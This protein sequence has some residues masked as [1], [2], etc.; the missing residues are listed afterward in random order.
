[1]P[2]GGLGIRLGDTFLGMEARLHD[3]KRDAMLAFIRANKLNRIITSGG[4]NAEDRRHHH[5]QGL[6]R[7][8]P[9]A[10]RARHRRG[11]LQRPG[12][13]HLQGRLPVA[14][15][16]AGPRRVRQ[17]PRSHHRGRGEALADR[18]PGARG[19]L[20]HREP[21]GRRRQEGRA[22]QLAVPG[23]GRARSE[24]RR[25]LYRRAAAQGRAERADRRPRCAPEGSAARA[26]G[27]AGRGGAHAVFLLR[28]PA[29]F[30]DRRAGRLARL[31]RHRLPFHG[32]MDGPLDAG[33]HP[34]GRRGRQLDRR[35]AVLQ[36]RRTC[37]RI[38]AT[39]PTTIPATWRS[40]PRSRRAST[41]PT[42][43]C[44]TTPSP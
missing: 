32:A 43:S 23:Q 8:A 26:G 13:A 4:R 11:A 6:S 14:D 24:R 20:R 42:R 36:A 31:C 37:S 35:G 22:G 16:Q 41:S 44:S 1:M 2:E 3:Y 15:Q 10:R 18:G 39:A 12:T 30:I 5:R 29:Q 28:L 17:G 27:D 33:L 9:G 40:A 19:A 25:D 34:H 21:A 7:R 38:S